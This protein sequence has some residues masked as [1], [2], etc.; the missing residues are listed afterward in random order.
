[1]PVARCWNATRVETVCGSAEPGRDY[2]FHEDGCRSGFEVATALSGVPLPW[3]ADAADAGR[4]VLPPPDLAR[5]GLSSHAGWAGA[6]RKAYRS[7]T[8]D[9]PVAVCRRLLYSFLRT[10]VRHGTL[11]LRYNDGTVHSFGDGTPCGCDSSPVTLRIFDPWFFVKTALEYY[12]GLSRSYMAGYFVV[13]PLQDA[14]E[15][16]PVLR[17]PDSR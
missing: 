16:H 8:Y 14:A 6:L 13:E 3:A 17:P 4:M 7:L 10:A 2:G 1:M 5:A 12:L 9:L 11:R 15:Y